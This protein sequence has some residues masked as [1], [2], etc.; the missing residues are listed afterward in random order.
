MDSAQHDA[1]I[2][3]VNEWFAAR[4]G[5]EFAVTVHTGPNVVQIAEG[6]F[7][8]MQEHPVSRGVYRA[9][10]SDARRV[11]LNPDEEKYVAFGAELQ[12][13]ET[14]ADRLVLDKGVQRVEIVDLETAVL[15][16]ADEVNWPAA[17]APAPQAPV[18]AQAVAPPPPPPAPPVP[19]QPAAPAAAP[20]AGPTAAHGQVFEMRANAPFYDNSY[21]SGFVG[22]VTIRIEEGWVTVTGK[23]SPQRTMMAMGGWAL[24]ILGIIGLAF[25]LVVAGNASGDSDMGF[26]FCLMGVGLL[27]LLPGLALYL[28]SRSKAMRSSVDSLQ[29]RLGDVSGGVARYDSNLGCLFMLLLTPLIGL[30][31]MLAMGRRIIRLTV[32][33]DR[34]TGPARQMLA[35]KTNSPAD[36]ALL[37]QVLRR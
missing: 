20:P 34:P 11:S 21:G 16:S 33:N 2:A 23:R 17:V 4:P 9:L 15:R 8:G 10:F 24:G 25:G 29:F 5:H 30:I 12:G 1:L 19:V 26:A 7:L 18:E 27:M 3:R 32:R 36:G 6:P 31:I 35:I 37:S 28:V 13:A 14:A 22:P